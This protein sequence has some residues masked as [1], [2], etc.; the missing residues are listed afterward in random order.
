[1]KS[2]KPGRGPSM[3]G[4]ISSLLVGAFGVVWTLLA[5]QA[6]GGLFALFGVIFVAVAVVQAVYHFKNAKSPHRYSAFDI[7]E[8]NEEPDPLQEKFSPTAHQD[9]NPQTPTRFCP[10]CG[11]PAEPDHRFCRACGKPLDE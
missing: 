5:F 10:Y 7:T 8:G 9:A 1:M 2:I 11:T 3:M 4:G 6:G